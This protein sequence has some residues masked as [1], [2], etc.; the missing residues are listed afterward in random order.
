M[1]RIAIIEDEV[2]FSDE[3][4]RWIGNAKPAIQIDR[5]YDRDS[6]VEAVTSAPYDLV[7]LDIELKPDR[8]AGIG[9]VNAINTNHRSPVLVVSGLDASIYRSIMRELDIW[10]YLGKPVNEQD[11]L[12]AVFGILRTA[13]PSH[14]G[15]ADPVDLVIDPLR[16]P[17]P[18]WRGKRLNLP[19]TAQ[20]ILKALHDKKGGVATYDELFALLPSGRNTTNLRQ[21]I[22][23]IREAFE[24]IDP[25]FDRIATVKMKGFQ[26]LE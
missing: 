13:R 16:Q 18:T 8:N 6:A 15:A 17:Q 4:Y 22:R 25:S 21:H 2:P 9:I 24:E 20:R 3:L 23:T 19:I 5:F 11:F 7:V 10:D 26:W 14:G 1:T 12:G